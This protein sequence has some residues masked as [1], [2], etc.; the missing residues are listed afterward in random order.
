M[1]SSQHSA[2]YK[3]Y[4]Y[5]PS[6]AAAVLFLALFS[7]TTALHVYQLLATR[8]W[9]MIPLVIGGICKQSLSCLNSQ[10]GQG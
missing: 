5:D 7:L 3:F 8:T 4:H 2:P 10:R 6:M 1:M 9:Y